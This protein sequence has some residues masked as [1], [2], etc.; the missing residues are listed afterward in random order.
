MITQKKNLQGLV[1]LNQYRGNFSYSYSVLNEHLDIK[2]D[3]GD[4]PEVDQLPGDE[5]SWCIGHVQAPTGGLLKDRTRI[6]P[7][8]SQNTYLY[9][10]GIITPRGIEFM[11][12][13]LNTDETFDTLL[14]HQMI[15]KHGFNILSDIEGG[16]GCVYIT[17]NGMFIFRTRHITLFISK[18]GISSERG[19]DMLCI[20]PDVVYKI[21]LDKDIS[22]SN[23]AEFKT[24]KYNFSIPG[25]LGK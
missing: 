7:T 14:L 8:Q 21:N 1:D 9:H 19:T 3:F 2:K 15:D 12:A 24:K 6:H 13:D 5:D 18:T 17:P 23:I 4:F 11:Q 20:N 16:F 22:Y 10:N 25:E